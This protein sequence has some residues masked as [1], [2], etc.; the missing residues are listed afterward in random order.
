MLTGRL[1][2]ALQA[3]SPPARTAAHTLCHC[4]CP[5]WSS[6]HRGLVSSFKLS[7]SSTHLCAVLQAE[8]HP[9]PA[10]PTAPSPPKPSLRLHLSALQVATRHLFSSKAPSCPRSALH[11]QP[12]WHGPPTAARAKA[13]AALYRRQVSLGRHCHRLSSSWD[14]CTLP[15]TCN[16]VGGLPSDIPCLLRMRGVTAT[17]LHWWSLCSRQPLK[18]QCCKTWHAS[19]AG[20]RR[21]T[22]QQWQSHLGIGTSLMGHCHANLVA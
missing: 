20:S 15:D 8:A 16:G 18:S 11:V 7:E 9:A 2:C 19:A 3:V 13:M 6:V 22:W 4:V 1:T 21:L 14:K 10:V 17:P 12:C 5:V